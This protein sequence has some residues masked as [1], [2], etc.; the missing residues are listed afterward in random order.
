MGCG[1]DV[2]VCM[3]RASDKFSDKLVWKVEYAF[4][5]ERWRFTTTRLV[6][7][8]LVLLE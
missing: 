7:G 2:V 4:V 6:V 8:E 3:G 1:L 5:V